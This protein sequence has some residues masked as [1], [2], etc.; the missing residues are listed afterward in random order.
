MRLF[1]GIFASIFRYGPLK[2]ESNLPEGEAEGQR[3]SA[4]TVSKGEPDARE[5]TI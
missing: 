5:E 3:G 4:S 2:A 1:R